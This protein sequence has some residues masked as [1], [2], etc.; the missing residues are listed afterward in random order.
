MESESVNQRHEHSFILG[1]IALALVIIV[2]ILVTRNMDVGHSQQ[3]TSG[4]FPTAP[5]LV[6]FDTPGLSALPSGSLLYNLYLAPANWTIT[7]NVV[8]FNGNTLTCSVPPLIQLRDCGTS[9]P[10]TCNSNP[11]LLVGAVT[12]VNTPTALTISVPV[13]LQG[14]YYSWSVVTGTC[15]VVDGSFTGSVSGHP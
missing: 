14:H 5:T 2:F 15:S 11:P 10:T 3:W 9:V 12:T 7:G 1:M 13:M 6:P 4:G 8:S